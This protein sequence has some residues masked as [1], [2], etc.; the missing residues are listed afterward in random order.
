MRRIQMLS[1]FVVLLL[2]AASIFIYRNLINQQIES[3]TDELQKRVKICA[4]KIEDYYQDFITDVDYLIDVKNSKVIFYEDNSELIKRTKRIYLKYDNLISSVRIYDIT[5]NMIIVNKD[6]YNYFKII[7]ISNSNTRNIVSKPRVFVEGY[8]YKYTIPLKN[9]AGVVFANVSFGLSIPNYIES[10]FSNFYLGKD[11]WQFLLNTKGY[12]MKVKY[13][14]EEFSSD[15]VIKVSSESFIVD[16]I[17]NGY[18]GVIRNEISYQSKNYKL[19]SVYYPVNFFKNRFGII[20]SIDER[21]VLSTINKNILVFFIATLMVLAIIIFIFIFIIRQLTESETRIRQSL[22]ALDKIVDNIPAGMIVADDEGIIQKINHS[23]ALLLGYESENK[24]KGK[25]ILSVLSLEPN[26][27]SESVAKKI[28]IK[29]LKDESKTILLT[30][31][32]LVL[33]NE[34][35]FLYTI[36]DIT[37]IEEAV[38]AKEA[39]AKAKTDFL[40]NISHEIRTPMNG[41]IGITDLLSDTD[42]NAEQKE[43]IKLIQDSAEVL[44]RIINDI[45]DFSKIE[46]GKMKIEKLPFNIRQILNTLFEQFTI[47][48]NAKGLQLKMDIRDDV[49]DNL[50]GDPIRLQQIITN[51]L[52]NS[53]KFTDSGFISLTC[54]LLNN[55]KKNA[56]ICF[57]VA[58]TG[59][60]I[61]SESINEIFKSF[62]QVDTSVS[63][64][65]GGT[66]LGLAISK[67]LIEMMGGEIWVESPSGISS[68]PSTP[69]SVFYIKAVFQVL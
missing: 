40:T 29:N 61:P 10:E 26:N 13:S 62:T 58:D 20:F 69:G 28:D 32:S 51:L 48:A 54:S 12:L 42:L 27:W 53:I 15:S 43:L 14:E 63:R 68:D 8:K 25:N 5:G 22:Q 21:A 37:E 65:Y 33:E 16:E 57:S 2:V 34:N 46:S 18:E 55:E 11:S 67:E 6:T 52:G 60:G 64:K 44:L 36:V 56:E 35:F 50:L 19:L 38:K 7:H 3:K 9:E 1:A 47:S 30:I 4:E 59:I 41:I 45:L 17:N 39:I 66:G 49:P 23:A 24:N 31:V